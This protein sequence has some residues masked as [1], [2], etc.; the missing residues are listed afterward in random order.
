MVKLLTKTNGNSL[1]RGCI[2]LLNF[3]LTVGAYTV[4][5]Y[6]PQIDK[7][8]KKKKNERIEKGPSRVPQD[9]FLY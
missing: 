4:Y 6:C 3:G 8:S 1:V 9:D 7:K 5:S 2:S